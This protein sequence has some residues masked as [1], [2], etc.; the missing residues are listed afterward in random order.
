[1]RRHGASPARSTAQQRIAAAAAAAA[2]I[3]DDA[4]PRRAVRQSV[5]MHGRRGQITSSLPGGGGGG[6]GGVY[7][8]DQSLSL[9]T[10]TQ[11]ERGRVR[12]SS[13]RVMSA[14][15]SAIHA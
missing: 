12:E 10:Q 3:N 11:T 14:L 4:V 13:G 7:R 15:L 6:G 5:Y 8:T 2:A 1:M 9:H